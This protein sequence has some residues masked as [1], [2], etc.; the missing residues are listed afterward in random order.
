MKNET[1]NETF[2]YFC[3]EIK[4]VAY[5]SLKENKVGDEKI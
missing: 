4:R 5:L 3:S 2:N 1:L